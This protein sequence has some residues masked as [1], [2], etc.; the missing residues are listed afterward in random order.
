MRVIDPMSPRCPARRFSCHPCDEMVTLDDGR[1]MPM[2]KTVCL[3]HGNRMVPQGQRKKLTAKLREQVETDEELL[4]RAAADG[5]LDH[6]QRQVGKGL[7]VNCREPASGATP[8]IC[9]ALGGKLDAMKM[10]VA[11]GA[12]PHLGSG[13]MVTPLSLAAQWGHREVVSWLLEECHVDPRQ[14]DGSPSPQSPLHH[15]RAREDTEMEQMIA[16]AWTRLDK[17]E[18]ERVSPA[19]KVES[20]RI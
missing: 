13:A 5:A 9:A 6:L 15:A 12:D 7:N 4:R 16:K 20:V 10:L 14:W 18:G 17:L 8:L 2:K 3:P 19:H 1:V 11:A